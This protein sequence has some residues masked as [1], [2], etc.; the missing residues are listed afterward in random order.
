MCPKALDL[1]LPR[2]SKLPSAQSYMQTTGRE[3]G[4]RIVFLLPAL[5][6][7]AIPA[8]Q[9]HRAPALTTITEWIWGWLL[10]LKWTSSSFKHRPALPPDFSVFM[11]CNLM[12][13]RALSCL[14]FIH[15]LP[16][17]S[18]VLSG[19][20]RHICEYQKRVGNPL[21]QLYCCQC[22]LAVVVFWGF[23]SLKTFMSSYCYSWTCFLLPYFIAP[24][25][26]S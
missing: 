19:L 7:G 21:R 25:W 16:L 17:L 8:G 10:N 1:R 22:I 13:E 20:C 15:Q 2:N 3:M 12:L 14:D 24:E 9:E 18:G 23:F 4:G 6:A 11:E 5:Q 26:K